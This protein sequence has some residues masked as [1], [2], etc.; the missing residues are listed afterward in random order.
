MSDHKIKLILFEFNLYFNI[1][2]LNSHYKE[3]YNLYEAN[4]FDLDGSTDMKNW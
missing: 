4:Q 3:F 1:I 2:N